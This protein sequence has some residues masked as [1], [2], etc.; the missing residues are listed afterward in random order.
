[1]FKPAK[2]TITEGIVDFIDGIEV[3][4]CNNTTYPISYD[5]SGTVKL[6]SLP[7]N[8][9]HSPYTS[10]KVNTD[11]IS[12]PDIVLK[13]WSIYK[14]GDTVRGKIINNTFHCL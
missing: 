12:K 14:H 8:N 1:M 7:N 4:R 6:Y 10:R 11:A 2:N 3:V 5:I 9:K 13:Y